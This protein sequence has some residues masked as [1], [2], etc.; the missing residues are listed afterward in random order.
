MKKRNVIVDINQA[1]KKLLFKL[2]LKEKKSI[3]LVFEQ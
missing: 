1:S 2:I 3:V